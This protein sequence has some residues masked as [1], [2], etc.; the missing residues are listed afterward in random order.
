METHLRSWA[1]SI[2]WRIIGIVILGAISYAFTR[3]WEQTTWITVIFHSLR[4]VLYYFHERWW[5]RISWGKIKHPLS[6]LPVKEDLTPEDHEAIRNFL[7][8][9]KC[10]SGQ[11]YEI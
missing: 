9:R 2:S 6:H 7:R 8:E 5:E 10:L 1:K 11:D 4:L 3:N